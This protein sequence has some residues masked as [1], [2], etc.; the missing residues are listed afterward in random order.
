M[1]SRGWRKP[2]G[3]HTAAWAS[4]HSGGR[5]SVKGEQCFMGL[6]GEKLSNAEVMPALG[7]AWSRPSSLPSWLRNR[8]DLQR[9][10]A[11]RLEN[12]G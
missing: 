2:G 4:G 5:G 1:F 8:L 11:A 3:S 9:R 7:P 6:S 12:R 10:A